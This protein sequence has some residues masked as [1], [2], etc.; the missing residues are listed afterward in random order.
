MGYLDFPRHIYAALPRLRSAQDI[1]RSR[2]RPRDLRGWAARLVSHDG[3]LP[4][5]GRSLRSSCYS[6]PLRVN[7][8]WLASWTASYRPISGR[9]HGPPFCNF[10][11]Q[12]S[13]R[14]SR[15]AA[16]RS[17][18]NTKSNISIRI[19]QPEDLL[20]T[21]HIYLECLRSDYV[22]K[23]K[24]YLDA[25][26]TS[27]ELVECE[28][29]LYASGK[30]NRVYVAMEGATMTG[31]IAVGPNLGQPPDHEGEVCGFFV[32]KA[33]RKMGIGLRL[34]KTGITCLRDLGYQK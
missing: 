33:Y 32:R 16:A 23:P 10:G 14:L 7:Q 6:V 15:A 20:E 13:W 5:S 29:W 12:V 30:P 26:N 18:M 24:A 2:R 3:C 4:L 25:K 27:D 11:K 21:V 34:L 31:Y 1:G 17:A 19:A 28:A 9:Y 22:C 8:E